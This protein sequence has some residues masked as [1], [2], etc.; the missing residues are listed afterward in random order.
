MTTAEDRARGGR[1]APQGD[2]GHEDH[3]AADGL[4]SPIGEEL[5]LEGLKKQVE[6]DFYAAITRPPAVYRGNPF[7]IEVGA[8]AT[9]AT[10]ARRGAD[11]PL[12]RFANRVPLQY[13]QSALRDHEGGDPDRLEELR[14]AAAARARCRSGPMVLMVHIAS[15]WVP[16]TSES[17]EAIAPTPRSSRRCGSRCRSAGG[18][19]GSS[20]G[21]AAARPTRRRSAPTSRSTSRT[22]ASRCRRSSASTTRRR[23]RS[24]RP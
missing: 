17:K 16:F 1:G 22:S 6:A 18:S 13:Q 9:A 8:R 21:A 2:P 24:A 23:R 20:S 5:I 3:G 4:L 11:R 7:L 14:P 19:W 10:P 12:I 15:V